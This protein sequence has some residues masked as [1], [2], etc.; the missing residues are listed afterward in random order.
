MIMTV[1]QLVSITLIV[2]TIYLA[3]V[4]AGLELARK[5]SEWKDNR[6]DN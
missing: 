6:N 2:A 4:V 5:I 3:L 1:L